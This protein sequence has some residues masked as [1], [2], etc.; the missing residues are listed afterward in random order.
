[1]LCRN[2]ILHLFSPSP[3][4]VLIC[5]TIGNASGKFQQHREVQEGAKE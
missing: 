4:H 1:M 3:W 5:R 2:A